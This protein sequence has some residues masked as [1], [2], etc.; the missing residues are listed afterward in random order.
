MKLNP[1]YRIGMQTRCFM[2]WLS[3][4]EAGLQQR[5]VPYWVTKIPLYLCILAAVGLMLAGAF[6]I[7]S[8]LA[9][10]VFIAFCL[11]AMSGNASEEPEKKS[12]LYD[13]TLNGYHHMGPEGPGVYVDG[14]RVSSPNDHNDD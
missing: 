7:A 12:V 8:F 11:S 13:E 2:R 10:M 1:G 9:L 6:F 14:I 4:W 5:G 3:K